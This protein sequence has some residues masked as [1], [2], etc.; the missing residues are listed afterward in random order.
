MQRQAK[1]AWGTESRSKGETESF[2]KKY[3]KIQPPEPEPEEEAALALAESAQG[4]AH[5]T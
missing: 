5:F 1:D 3:I 2:I 4:G